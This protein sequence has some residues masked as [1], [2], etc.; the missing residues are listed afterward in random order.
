MTPTSASSAT[1]LAR[2]GCPVELP[3]VDRIVLVAPHPDDEV[4]SSGLLLAMA[5]ERRL[6]VRVVAV[7]GGEAAYPGQDPDELTQIRRG[8]QLA[9]LAEVGIG[10]EQVTRCA[11]PD[12]R[13]AE[14]LD[15]L[16]SVIARHLDESVATLLV[17]PSIHDWHPDHEACG[18]AARSALDLLG[19][20][21]RLVHW[22]S[23][24]WAHHHP[25]RLLT[26][27][28]R[29]IRL[30]GETPQ[31]AAR[32]RAVARHRSQFIAPENEQ[33]VL[34]STLIAHLAL[35]VELYVEEGT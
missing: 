12:G 4:L 35:P 22:S 2:R 10:T 8:E 34:D 19:G 15:R 6:D 16:T 1:S 28:P 21:E 29:L 3:G 14:H 31:V 32:A 30:R 20:R 23:L 33:P 5:A 25:D 9:A 24:F 27:R 18:R 11:L 17:A 26:S 13:V 7:T